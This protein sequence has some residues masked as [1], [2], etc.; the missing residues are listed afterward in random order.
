M[1]PAT[2]SDYALYIDDPTVISTQEEV[3][4]EKGSSIVKIDCV[5]GQLDQMRR[6][7]VSVLSQYP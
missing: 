1:P 3:L 7:E 6:L 4:D 5:A 2:S